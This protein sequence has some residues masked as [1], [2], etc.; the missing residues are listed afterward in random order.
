MN[1]VLFQTVFKNHSKNSGKMTSLYLPDIMA[2]I[3]SV[4]I[5]KNY[6]ITAG[7]KSVLIKQQEYYLKRMPWGIFYTGIMRSEDMPSIS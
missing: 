1:Y 4:L 6:L 5:I 3:S 7:R 2:D